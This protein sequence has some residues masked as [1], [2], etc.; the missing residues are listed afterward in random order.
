MRYYKLTNGVYLLS[1]GT[2]NIGE[3]ITDEEYHNILNIIRSC[4]TAPEGYGYRLKTDLTFE[5][6]APDVPE[7]AEQELT[8]E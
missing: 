6:Y 1:I 3:E 4:P 8:A 7:D 2:G 5:L